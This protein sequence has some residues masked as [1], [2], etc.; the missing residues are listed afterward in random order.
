MTDKEKGNALTIIQ[1]ILGIAT[2]IGAVAVIII[3]TTLLRG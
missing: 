2:I 1:W 3:A